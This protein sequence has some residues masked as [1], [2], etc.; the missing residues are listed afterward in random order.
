M[1]GTKSLHVLLAVVKVTVKKASL[2]YI[3]KCPI[4]CHIFCFEFFIRYNAESISKKKKKVAGK[5]GEY[6]NWRSL[7]KWMNMKE[8]E[9][10]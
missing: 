9:V 6:G 4:L 3:S 2:L 5:S 7:E 10:Q 1:M 8:I